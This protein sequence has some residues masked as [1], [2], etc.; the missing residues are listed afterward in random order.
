MLRIHWND[1]LR[2]NTRS[3]FHNPS[4]DQSGHSSFPSW[5]TCWPGMGWLKRALTPCCPKFVWVHWACLQ[6]WLGAC[7]TW[8]L[9]VLSALSSLASCKL[10]SFPYSYFARVSIDAVLK[11]VMLCA[12]RD[13]TLRQRR[14]QFQPQGLPQ[15]LSQARILKDLYNH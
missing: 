7:W 6:T 2:G 10:S 8:T 3:T 11:Y 12:G 15:S 14:I 4:S 1:Y 9:A 13:C 5:H